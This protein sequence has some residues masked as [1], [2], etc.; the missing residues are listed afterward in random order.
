[1]LASSYHTFRH[2]YSGTYPTY[3][4]ILAE[5]ATRSTTVVYPE[6]GIVATTLLRGTPYLVPRSSRQ[7]TEGIQIP[8]Y[9]SGARVA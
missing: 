5:E 7:R 2:V 6:Y 1:M 3:D 9:R 4:I 8:I